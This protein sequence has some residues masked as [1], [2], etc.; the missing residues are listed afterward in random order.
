MRVVVVAPRR[1]ITQ[2]SIAD[3]FSLGADG[4]E[5]QVRH[6][7]DHRLV[8]FGADNLAN[9]AQETCPEEICGADAHTQITQEQYTRDMGSRSITQMTW[10]NVLEHVMLSNGHKLTLLEDVVMTPENKFLVLEPSA[11]SNPSETAGFLAEKA[12]QNSWPADNFQVVLEDVHAFRFFHQ[13]APAHLAWYRRKVHR[14]ARGYTHT[15]SGFLPSPGVS[16]AEAVASLALEAQA[17]IDQAGIDDVRNTWPDD[18]AI[19]IGVSFE[20]AENVVGASVTDTVLGDL[21]TAVEYATT[22]SKLVA[23]FG[24]DDLHDSDSV[25]R[26]LAMRRLD[27]YSFTTHLPADVRAWIAAGMPDTWAAPTT[28][29]PTTP[30]PEGGS[31][32]GM[33]VG[34]VIFLVMLCALFAFV[35]STKSEEAEMKA[36]VEMKA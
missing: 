16:P 2:Q 19:H 35:S 17:S 3:L 1:N 23:A 22:H 14:F 20:A 7:L 25:D 6:T 27:V 33:I 30:E 10:V 26:A 15:A 5:C 13:Q 9:V 28:P 34:I 31:H 8:L 24:W 29:A 18:D 4:V 11:P 21:V 36:E 32:W 12:N